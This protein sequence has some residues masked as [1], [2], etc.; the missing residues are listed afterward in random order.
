VW[1]NH[2]RY[3]IFVLWHSRDLEDAMKNRGWVKGG[4]QFCACGNRC[5]HSMWERWNDH[6]DVKRIRQE[7][8]VWDEED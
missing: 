7:P 5:Q 1:R 4:K 2:R 6:L 8:I 3:I